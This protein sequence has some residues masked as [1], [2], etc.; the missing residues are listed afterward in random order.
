MS[1]RRVF[2]AAVFLT[3]SIVALACASQRAATETEKHEEDTS[4]VVTP[5]EV[6][7]KDMT[8]KQRGRY[9]AK[10]VTP[11]MHEVFQ[12]YDATRYEKFGCATCHGKN[13]KEKGFKMPNPD[14]PALPAS[15]QEFMATVMKEK[16][17]MVKFMAEQVTPQTAAL[18][19][20]K[21]FDPKNPDPN[22]FGCGGCHTI[23]GM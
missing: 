17:E 7:W 9:M 10:V 6:P 5:A 19:G 18:L 20:L 16:P 22:A 15:E 3:T 21:V 14:L 8:Q 1:H 11:K 2:L 23:K 13:A 4:P 12:A